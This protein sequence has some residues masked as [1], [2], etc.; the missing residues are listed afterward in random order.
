MMTQEKFW[1][2]IEK[3]KKSAESDDYGFSQ[4][5]MLDQFLQNESVEDCL[6]F[7]FLFGQF[8][9]SLTTGSDNQKYGVVAAGW[10][11]YKY[12][13]R[14]Q[15]ES[16]ET[17]DNR[18]CHDIGF[19]VYKTKR[20][21]IKSEITEKEFWFIIEKTFQFDI[22]HHLL[23]L[24]QYLQ[25]FILEDL[26]QFM[27]ISIQLRDKL[28]QKFLHLLGRSFHQDFA[29]LFYTGNGLDYRIQEGFILDG[30]K[31][32][33]NATSLLTLLQIRDYLCLEEAAL[34]STIENVYYNKTGFPDLAF[35]IEDELSSTSDFK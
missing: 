8:S 30:Q 1:E 35:E 23:I 4:S 19:R 7:G 27:R 13:A 31:I 32:Y 5:E 16:I 29:C 21:P 12:F 3:S 9:N 28:T 11:T 34:A 10:Q 17:F 33:D 24:Q 22:N 14:N 26:E 18:F 20:L 25:D 6:T 2:Y 15:N